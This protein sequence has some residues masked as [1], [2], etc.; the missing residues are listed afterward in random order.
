[1]QIT[2]FISGSGKAASAIMESLGVI[3]IAKPDVSILPSRR[4][5]RG[6]PLKVAD[7]INPVLFIA[8]P[9]ALHAR[10]ILEG[11]RAG[12]VLI[13]CEKPAAVS[14]QQIGNLRQ[15]RVPVAVCHGYRQMWGVQTL[16]EMID[17]GEFGEI[18]SVEGRYWQSSTANQALTGANVQTWKNDP[19][20]SGPSDALID[21][22]SHWADAALFL[23]GEAPD[24][25]ALW[26]SYAN[27]AAP[28]RDSHAH[29]QMTFP[30][31]TRALASISKTV[32]GAPNHFE[33]NVIGT[34]KYACWKFLEEDQIEVGVGSRRSYIA[35]NRA[36]IGSGHWPFHGMG[37]LEGYIEII[38][39]AIRGL[40]D[41]TANYP[42][43]PQNLEVM[44]LL[45]A[46]RLSSASA[47]R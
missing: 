5:K 18:I 37:W 13:V 33:V 45:L 6:E 40:E 41:G 14:A 10:S 25:T 9:H 23:I 20:L 4:L 28:H 47:H 29:L 11:E 44:S 38:Y 19:E 1:M 46:A 36:D 32:H 39:Q 7:A 12:F 3:A 21:I 34:R 42:T 31:G 27:A 43:L 16:R 26:L 30:G 2:P 24:D 35:R 15:V 8:S 22:G 17:A